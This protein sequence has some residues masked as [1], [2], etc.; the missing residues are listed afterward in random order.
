VTAAEW[1]DV[2][3][4]SALRQL[5]T[6]GLGGKEVFVVEPTLKVFD[7]ALVSAAITCFSPGSN[8]TEV[9]F[10]QVASTSELKKLTGGVGVEVATARAERSW[11][12]LVRGG[13]PDRP[14]GFVE[15]GELFKV[16]RGQVTGANRVWVQR[17]DTTIVPSQFLVPAIT[18]SMDITKVPSRIIT[19]VDSLR[20]VVSLPRDL[21]ELEKS[22]QESIDKFL[23]WA[24]SLG[25]HEGY[26]AQHRK[27]WWSVSFGKPAPIVM[28]YMGRRPPVFALNK[29]GARLINVAHGLYPRQEF[30]EKYLIKMLTWLNSNVSQYSGRTYAGGLT[31]F[32]PSEAMR[33]LVPE[34]FQ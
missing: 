15:L 21:S 27:P 25:A 19:D 31:K 10:K 12:I 34:S 30:D 2:N 14:S 11:S 18:E 1:L 5:L 13:R 23:A 17:T 24:K 9:K 22:D 3:Y 32:E 4:G 29:A 6:N 20:R 16:S 7:D 28:T 26:V 33:L 8:R